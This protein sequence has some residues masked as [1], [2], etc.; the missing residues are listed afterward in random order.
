MKTASERQAGSAEARPA[1]E[2][3]QESPVSGSAGP[4][5]WPA[6]DSDDPA[7]RRLTSGLN[8]GGLHDDFSLRIRT[9]PQAKRQ[10]ASTLVCTAS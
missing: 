2:A 3:R 6:N 9:D 8:G 7:S 10:W 1:A 5:V 4:A